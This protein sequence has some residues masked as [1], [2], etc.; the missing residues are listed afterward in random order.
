LQRKQVQKIDREVVQQS[1]RRAQVLL[2]ILQCSFL[3]MQLSLGWDFVLHAK[4]LITVKCSFKCTYNGQIAHDYKVPY[5]GCGRIWAGWQ[6]RG[7]MAFGE[8]WVTYVRSK[9]PLFSKF[10]AD[11]A[12]TVQCETWV[13]PSLAW[14]IRVECETWFEHS[15]AWAISYNRWNVCLWHH[16]FSPGCSFS[17]I[18]PTSHPSHKW[19]IIHEEEQTYEQM[20]HMGKLWIWK[21]G[22]LLPILLGEPSSDGKAGAWIDIPIFFYVRNIPGSKHFKGSWLSCIINLKIPEP[23]I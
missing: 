15:L 4:L 7:I 23:W 8:L 2:I 5:D 18:K 6:L 13:E 3:Y 22:C 19:N 11:N 17:F 10:A 16:L 14:A 12:I 9:G 21:I 20:K 1:S